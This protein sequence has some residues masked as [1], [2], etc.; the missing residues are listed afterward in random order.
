MTVVAIDGPAGAGKSTVARLLAEQLG[1]DYLDTGAMYRAVAWAA[2]EAGLDPADDEVV[3]L[4]L[5]LAVSSGDAVSVGGVDVTEQIRAPLVNRAVSAVAAQP[6]VRAELVELQRRWIAERGG[7]VVEGRDI[8]TVVIPEAEVKVFLTARPD[9]RARRRFAESSGQELD[10]IISD[11]ERRDEVDSRRDASPMRP[12]EDAVTIDTSDCDA[13]AI[14]AEI[15]AL[16][17]P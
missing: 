6:A 10:E 15:L 4:V 17:R 3:S 9:V 11:I 13:D 2:L 14:V 16:V 8:G 7:G 1:L 5:Q 12:A